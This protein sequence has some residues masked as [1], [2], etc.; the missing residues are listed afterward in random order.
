MIRREFSVFKKE[1]VLRNYGNRKIKYVI[2]E[3]EKTCYDNKKRYTVAESAKADMG[4][5]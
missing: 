1:D 5:K 4:E 2:Y 3:K